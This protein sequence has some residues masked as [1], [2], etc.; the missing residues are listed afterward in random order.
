MASETENLRAIALDPSHPTPTDVGEIYDETSDSLTDMLGG[1]IHVGYWEDPSKQETAEVVGDRLTREVG[2]RL[3]P[4]QGEHIL[5]VGCGTGKST[6]Q[7]AGIYDAQVTGITISKQ[8]VEVARSQYGR[9]MPAGQ[10]HFQFADA[11]DLPFGDASFDGAYA[12]ESLVHMLDKRTALAQIAQVLRPGSRLVIAD[13]VSDHPC[14]DSPVLARYAE[15]FEPP[16]VSAD[17]LQNLLRQAGFK[18]IDVTDIRENIRPS[19]KLFETKGL[20]LG[21]EL[22]QKLL[23]I[24]SILEEMNELGYAL[25]TAERL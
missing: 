22:G 18:V 1:Y 6:A 9:K 5:D 21:G 23:E 4:A 10:V 25:I 3:S 12:I 15:I 13:L 7:L 8:Q 14:P 20:S 11:M 19:C 2:V 16:L 17:D 24:A